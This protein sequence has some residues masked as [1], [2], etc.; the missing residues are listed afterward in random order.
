M[1]GPRAK[2]WLRKPQ[3]LRHGMLPVRAFISNNSLRLLKMV[4]EDVDFMGVLIIICAA[5][6]NGMVLIFKW[7]SI[8]TNLCPMQFWG[9]KNKPNVS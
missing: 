1:D 6:L 4:K 9:P 2:S 5:H 7:R 8:F 3:F